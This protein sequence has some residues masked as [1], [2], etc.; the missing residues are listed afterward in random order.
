MD[1][2]NWIQPKKKGVRMRF[3]YISSRASKT[4]TGNIAFKKVFGKRK[5]T[6]KEDY[7]LAHS[8]AQK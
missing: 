3:K 1:E 6:H 4:E 7:T 2:R 8:D 5:G